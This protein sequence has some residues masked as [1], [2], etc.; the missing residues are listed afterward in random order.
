MSGLD[1]TGRYQVRE[2][3]RELQVR[4]TTIVFSSHILGDV[5]SICDRVAMLKSGKVIAAGQ[6][7]ELLPPPKEWEWV[8]SFPTTS[9]GSSTFLSTGT[10]LGNQRFRWITPRCDL[11]Q[12]EFKQALELGA[13][14]ESVIPH[15]PSLED[16]FLSY[17][18]KDTSQSPESSI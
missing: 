3:L 2:M 11:S 6:L 14:I 13:H 15:R 16:V 18:E 7:D 10:P 1:P 12:P 9:E 4:G 8:A 5:A 17:L